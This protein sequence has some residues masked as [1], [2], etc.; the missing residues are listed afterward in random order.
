M[1]TAVFRLQVKYDF[2]HV[3]VL[4][5]LCSVSGARIGSKV[6]ATNGNLFGAPSPAKSFMTEKVRGLHS[7]EKNKSGEYV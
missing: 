3:L 7:K 6:V 2:D 1:Y 4:F 5:L